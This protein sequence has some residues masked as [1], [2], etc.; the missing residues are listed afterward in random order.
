MPAT[1]QTT[2]SVVTP[3]VSSQKRILFACMPADGHFNPLTSL[4]VHL[5]AAGHDVRW[6]TG[7]IFAKKLAALQI[8]YLPFKHAQEITVQNIDEVYP[9]RREIKSQ[10]K[11]LSFDICHYFILRGPEFY[12]DIKEMEQAFPFDILIA[13]SAFTGIPFVK[14]KLNKPVIAVGVTP[15]TETSKDL[16]PALLGLT[17]TKGIF[18]RGKQA[19][20]RFLAEKILFREPNKVMR[21][22]LGAHGIDTG[23]YNIFDALIQKSTVFLQ[24]GTPGFEYQRSDLS[25][26]IHFIGPLLPYSESAYQ[27]LPFLD[28]LKSYKKVILVTQGTFEADSS[29]LIIPTLEAYKNSDYLVIVTTAGWHT[30]E[31]RAKYPYANCLIEDFIP[32]SQI[33]PLVDV[34][35][36]NGGYGGVLLSIA[37][38]LPMVV[39]G[40]HEGKNEICARVGYF[41]LGINL[42]TETPAQ[43]QIKVA[44]EQVLT[45]KTY[46]ENVR[47]LAAEF[48]QYNAPLLCEQYVNQL[49]GVLPEPSWN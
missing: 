23:R 41:K 4:A 1:I 17:P 49:T 33:M 2:I 39:G 8:P 10:V 31:L 48:T 22:V 6:Y 46:R 16:P 18:G 9:Q 45:N 36:S 43:Q 26:H 35:V 32:F 11:K 20:Q 27:P 7:S 47:A 38:H 21:R 40:Q 42:K 5:K 12:A 30:A 13:D 15:L 24:S 19:L 3:S 14:E 44:V 37:N 34:Y 25:S 29:K 28:K